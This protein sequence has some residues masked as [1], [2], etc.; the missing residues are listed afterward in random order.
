MIE[1]ALIKSYLQ[2]VA[3]SVDK[4]VYCSDSHN[5]ELE[6]WYERNGDDDIEQ[7]CATPKRRLASNEYPLLDNVSALSSIEDRTRVKIR[8]KITSLEFTDPS[9]SKLS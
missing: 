7:L 4:I 5:Q 8:D 3:D 2:N 9:L 6:L 1:N